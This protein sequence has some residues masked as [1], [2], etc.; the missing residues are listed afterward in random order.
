MPPAV[1]NTLVGA[2]PAE[3][4]ASYVAQVGEPGRI[5][6]RAGTV[7]LGSAA[8]TVAAIDELHAKIF[9]PEQLRALQQTGLAQFDF[10]LPGI[11]GMFTALAGA[12]PGDRWLDIR[13][14]STRM[15]PPMHPAVLTPPTPLPSPVPPQARVAPTQP[16]VQ[17][18][19][20]VLVPPPAPAAPPASML[21][22]A[23]PPLSDDLTDFAGLEFPATRLQRGHSPAVRTD[24]S[25][26][27]PE[28]FDDLNDLASLDFPSRDMDSNALTVTDEIFGVT[29]TTGASESFGWNAESDAALSDF[30]EPE[31]KR[32]SVRLPVAACFVG[33]LAVAGYFGVTQF[34]SSDPAPAPQPQPAARTAPPPARP[35]PAPAPS[36][37]APQTTA[38]TTSTTPQQ[39]PP[40]AV[41]PVQTATASPAPAT[42]SAATRQTP[43]SAVTPAATSAK[44]ATATAAPPPS[45]AAPQQ[46]AAAKPQQTTA[47][48]APRTT[49]P[50]PAATTGVPP[51]QAFGSESQSRSGYSIQ[52]AAVKTRE[53]ADRIVSRFV[54]QGYPA[55]IIRGEGS[56][57]SYY[58]VRIGGFAD[59]ESAAKV[60]KQ[61]EGTEGIKPWI[62]KEIPEAKSAISQAG[63][64]EPSSRR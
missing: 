34:G 58:R 24:A 46:A 27:A 19:Q 48:A 4:G 32:F 22:A 50:V 47:A 10:A 12:S 18:S 11:D 13:R 63:Q 21:S 49:T 17:L 54:T 30:P 57:A 7:A 1:I 39:A 33:V 8:L 36:T 40:P 23:P 41:T 25:Q 45:A 61:L 56:A 59:R 43:A 9:P 38:A 28:G 52:V 55:Y 64:Q 51:A 42:S 6:S 60:A 3:E 37:P 29:R 16:V 5:T 14:R 35:N 2:I 31:R 26:E 20:P 53:E 62:A 15:P 44:T